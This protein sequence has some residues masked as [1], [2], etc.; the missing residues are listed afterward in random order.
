MPQ[1]LKKDSDI[2]RGN[3]DSR[4]S[5]SGIGVFKWK[6]NNAVYLASNY[7]GNETTT[8]YYEI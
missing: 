7:H 4:F 5:N 2:V 8:I 1:N 3:F 6:D